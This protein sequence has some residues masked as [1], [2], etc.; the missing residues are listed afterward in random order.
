VI[1]EPGFTGLFGDALWGQ[2]AQAEIQGTAGLIKPSMTF[3]Q[4]SHDTFTAMTI[5]YKTS[6]GAGTAR[7]AGKIIRQTE[8]YI[9]SAV[10]T[11]QN[12]VFPCDTGNFIE[13][14][15]ENNTTSGGNH[16]NAIVDKAANTWASQIPGAGE[17]AQ[18]WNV[19]AATCNGQDFAQFQ[20]TNNGSKTRITAYE[21]P[22]V[23][24][25]SAIDTGSEQY[26]A[27][28]QAAAT[29]LSA[30]VTSAGQTTLSLTTP[31]DV[32]NGEYIM[33]STE[34]M[35][36][37]C[38]GTCT[39]PVTV[40]RGQWDSTA[41]ATIVTSTSVYPSLQSPYPTGSTGSNNELLFCGM[42]TGNGP[43]WNA[44]G[45]TSE[46]LAFNGQ[47]DGDVAYEPTAGT[48]TVGWYLDNQSAATTG[49]G[50][51]EA[52]KLN[53]SSAKIHHKVTEE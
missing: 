12:F 6:A 41:L 38:T 10:G 20:Y 46:S 44:S 7:Q 3:I 22:N 34:V 36:V 42:N 26:V 48:Y 23:V 45:A 14:T 1:F 47:S 31:A 39:N 52:I 5:A 16:V 24:T 11:S 37:S 35:L 29:T 43:Q 28:T 8:M 50:S 15:L 13:I 19:T 4:T 53:I 49:Y 18:Y 32:T 9:P 25:S 27:I 21:V 51:A 30:G 17:Y 2:S 40:A 33:V